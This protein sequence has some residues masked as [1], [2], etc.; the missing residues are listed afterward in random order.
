RRI[1]STSPRVAGYDLPNHGRVTLIAAPA[2]HPEVLKYSAW[3]H[4]LANKLDKASQGPTIPLI[5]VACAVYNLEAQIEGMRELK[6]EG[7]F[8]GRRYNFGKLSAISD[9]SAALGSISKSVLGEGNTFI[10]IINKPR[11]EI[12]KIPLLKQWA[13]NLHIQTGSS[14]LPIL[15]TFSAF[16]ML[17][18]TAITIWDARR[19][20][21]QG[22]L[23]TA[24]AYGVAAS[25]GAAW[26]AYIFGMSINP[27]VLIAGAILFIAAS[28]VA[29]WL[30]DSDIE[31]LFKNGPFG[32]YHRETR[33]PDIVLGDG[34]RFRHLSE[35]GAAYQQLLG[36]L[37]KPVIKAERL[38]DWW[39]SAPLDVR[40]SLK[41]IDQQRKPSSQEEKCV[42]PAAQRLEPDDWV[43]IV[44]SPLFSMFQPHLFQL[45]AREDLALLY[46]NG[47]FNAERVERREI[48]EPKLAAYP[49]GGATVMYILPK[50]FPVQRQ[51]PIVRFDKGIIHRLKV[52]GQFW[53]AMDAERS[54]ALVL[55]QP[56]PKMWKPYV[57]TYWN[58]PPLSARAGDAVY[59]QIETSEFEV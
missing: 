30:V 32:Q 12:S 27:V 43:V 46:Y 57:S 13:E 47:A 53:L 34:D 44:H 5:A 35:P 42:R 14:K 39:Q 19:A 11:F 38:A 56:N 7:E 4:A 3:K 8:G 37:G 40:D 51:T 6:N 15:R 21:Q 24:F 41:R 20:W 59:W 23:D 26:T 48:P 49:V 2:D 1:G 36:V 33:V 17:A 54:K 25:G 10:K 52:F 18:T 31:T 9:L 58:R 55:P 28:V 50:Q 29:G 45:Y 22:D 16:A